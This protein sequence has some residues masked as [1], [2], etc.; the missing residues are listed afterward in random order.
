MQKKRTTKPIRRR[1]QFV[2]VVVTNKS[3]LQQWS[4]SGERYAISIVEADKSQTKG[5]KKL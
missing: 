1:I 4:A 2:K 3:E 5:L